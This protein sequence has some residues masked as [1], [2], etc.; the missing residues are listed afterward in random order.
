MLSATTL[1]LFLHMD[2]IF[3]AAPLQKISILQVHFIKYI[4][5]KFKYILS[6]FYV[7]SI[8]MSMY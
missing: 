4:Y 2:G 3:L 6:I 5:V 1:G 7:V 8:P